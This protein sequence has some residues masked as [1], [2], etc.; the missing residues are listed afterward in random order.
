[1][2]KAQLYINEAM[3]MIEKIHGKSHSSLIF[4][5]QKLGILNLNDGKYT[6]ALKNLK[7]SKKLIK[8]L[9]KNNN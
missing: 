2:E 3:R 6:E 9:F 1:M 4:C 8:N 5:M 7:D